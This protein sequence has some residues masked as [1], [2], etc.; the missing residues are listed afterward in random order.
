MHVSLQ[1]SCV[2][3]MWCVWRA[4]S[5]PGRR[6][7]LKVLHHILEQEKFVYRVSIP[8][9]TSARMEFPLINGNDTVMINSLTLTAN[10]LGGKIEGG[11]MIFE[12]TAGDYV[13]S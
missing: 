6:L 1:M 13:I 2:Q 3:A 4:I 9:G 12:L 11:K 8:E 10:E 7:L 5:V